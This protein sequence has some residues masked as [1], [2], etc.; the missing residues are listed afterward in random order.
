[1]KKILLIIDPQND[2]ISGSLA[3]S[4]AS[5]AI[6]LLTDNLLSES[7]TFDYVI[8]TSDS[9]PYNHCSFIENGGLWPAHCV[10]G[11]SGWGLDTRL[12]AAVSLLY[13]DKCK[14][15]DKGINPEIEEYSVLSNSNNE[16]GLLPILKEAS[17]IHICGIAGD[18]CVAETIK[19]LIRLGLSD[20]LIVRKDYIAS[21]DSGDIL[22]EIISESGIKCG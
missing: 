22:N 18:F 21:T 15:V 1:M 8:I 5:Q 7:E 11:T 13:T 9:H 14:I 3:V 20:R 12:A 19:D 2:F 4:G 17:E 6:N 10:I 16:G